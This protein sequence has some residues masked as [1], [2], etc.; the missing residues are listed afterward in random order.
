MKFVEPSIGLA[1][2]ASLILLL[3]P[4][5]DPRHERR[6]NQMP[7]DF[8]PSLYVEHGAAIRS[9]LTRAQRRTSRVFEALHRAQ[10]AAP[11]DSRKERYD[12]A[13]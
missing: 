6:K 3:Q 13:A 5:C 7:Y 4:G 11:W 12:L 1:P 8:R 2:P 9:A 10:Y